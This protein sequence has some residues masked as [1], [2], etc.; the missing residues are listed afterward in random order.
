M[1]EYHAEVHAVDMHIHTCMH[2][3]VH[4]HICEYFCIESTSEYRPICFE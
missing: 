3:C 1:S 2:V 4:V